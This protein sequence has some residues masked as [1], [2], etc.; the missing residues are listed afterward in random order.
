M[1]DVEVVPLPL[2][3]VA[4]PT[5]FGVLPAQSDVGL[6]S[7]QDGTHSDQCYDNQC[8]EERALC[9]CHETHFK[10]H[11][12]GN[13]LT[14]PHGRYSPDSLSHGLRHTGKAPPKVGPRN[15]SLPECP[16]MPSAHWK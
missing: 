15:S 13:G 3:R 8:P 5:E 2:Q 1:G 12:Y 6:A 7:P 16:H 11:G 9:K 10:C 4:L 14:L